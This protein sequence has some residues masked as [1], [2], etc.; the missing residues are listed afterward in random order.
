MEN[1]PDACPVSSS[2]LPHSFSHLWHRVLGSRA[3]FPGAHCQGRVVWEAK[4]GMAGP[5]NKV[6]LEREMLL[7]QLSEFMMRWL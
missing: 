3:V 1:S 6:G 2:P 5:E 7:N 4:V